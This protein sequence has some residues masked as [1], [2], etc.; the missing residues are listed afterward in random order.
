MHIVSV[1]CRFSLSRHLQNHSTN[2][3][4]NQRDKKK[5]EYSNSL[6]KVQVCAMFRAGD[7]RRSFTQ[8]YMALYEDAMFV[9]LSG[10]QI[11]RPE[12]NKNMSAIFVIKSL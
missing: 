6:A 7:V 9:S 5:D 1:N 3:V 12:A 11:W 4:K 2:K 10:A 8:I